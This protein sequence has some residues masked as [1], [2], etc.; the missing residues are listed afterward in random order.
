MRVRRT[1]L[2]SRRFVD[3]RPNRLDKDMWVGVRWFGTGRWFRMG[4]TQRTGLGSVG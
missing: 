2:C 4:W 1:Y 3:F